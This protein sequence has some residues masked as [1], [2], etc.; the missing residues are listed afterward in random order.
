L[1]GAGA[2]FAF[3]YVLNLLTNEFA[4]LCGRR[5]TLLLITVRALDYAFFWHGPFLFGGR[6]PADR[7]SI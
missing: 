5:L 7:R 6:L 4:R 3:P 1:N 2:V